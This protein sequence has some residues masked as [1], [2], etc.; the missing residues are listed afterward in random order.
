MLSLFLYFFTFS[1]EG[2]FLTGALPA[3]T[4]EHPFFFIP[5]FFPCGITSYLSSKRSSWSLF[6]FW[7][8]LCIALS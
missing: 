2:F 5:F 6:S 7:L 1:P 3:R 4:G 8:R